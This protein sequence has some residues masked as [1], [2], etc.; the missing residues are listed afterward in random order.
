M[1]SQ[2][3]FGRKHR[4]VR[5]FGCEIARLRLLSLE[6]RIVPTALP[7]IGPYTPEQSR[8]ARQLGIGA[9]LAPTGQPVDDPAAIGGVTRSISFG[10]NETAIRAS[11]SA[12]P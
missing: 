7:V 8:L 2:S 10:L 3:Y 9:W 6:G 1:A 5:G 11:L 4:V 12:A